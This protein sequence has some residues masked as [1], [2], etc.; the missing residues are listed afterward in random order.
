MSRNWLLYLDDIIESAEKIGRLTHDRSYE[1]FVADEAAFDAVRQ[2]IAYRKFF[3][4]PEP[5]SPALTRVVVLHEL[6]R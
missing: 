2:S 5:C 1:S 6:P 4:R 3:R